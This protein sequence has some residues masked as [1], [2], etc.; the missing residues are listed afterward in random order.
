MPGRPP[1][2]VPVACAAAPRHF[3]CPPPARIAALALVLV[4]A[5]AATLPACPRHGADMML[6]PHTAALLVDY[7]EVFLR[8]Q[9]VAAFRR[10]VLARYTDGTLARLV[11]SGGAQARRAAVLA[12]GL[13]GS[14]EA[15]PVVAAALRDPDP[16]VRDLA[17]SALWAIWFRADSPEHNAM[18]QEVRDLNDRQRYQDAFDLATRLIA[19]SPHFAEAFN[20]RAIAAFFL[21]RL[22]DSEAD[23]LRTLERNPYHTGALAGLG[24]CYIRMGRRGEALKTF[25]RALKLQP[26]SRGLRETVSALEEAAD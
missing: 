8:D 15:N 23:C 24:Q 22:P 14:F 11:R 7:F 12:L 1:R 20:Q 10:S 5:L 17:Q 9:D 25:R 16:T 4:V 6:E 3:R 2:T 13:N 21:D 19:R 26:Y 18:L